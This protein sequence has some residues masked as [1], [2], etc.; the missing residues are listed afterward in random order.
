MSLNLGYFLF[1]FIYLFFKFHIEFQ[2]SFPKLWF[3]IPVPNQKTQYLCR[4]KNKTKNKQTYNTTI[5]NK[6]QNK[7]TNKRKKENNRNRIG[8]WRFIF[9]TNVTFFKQHNFVLHYGYW[10]KWCRGLSFLTKYLYFIH[11]FPYLLSS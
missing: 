11:Q 10:L 9:Y 6:I 3:A 1:Y 5:N 4:I 2:H 7:Q 8:K